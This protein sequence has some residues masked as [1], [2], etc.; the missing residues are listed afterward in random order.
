MTA[1]GKPIPAA[2]M[3]KPTTSRTGT[4][5]GGKPGGVEGGVAGGKDGGV[6]GSKGMTLGGA[7]SSKASGLPDYYART[8]LAHIGRHFKVPDEQKLDATTTVVFTIR[9]DGTIT[10]ARVRS[11]SGSSSLDALAIKALNDSKKVMALPDSYVGNSV[12][13]EVGFSFNE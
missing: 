13:V 2:G 1:S 3:G 7:G 9:R 8:V 6:V 4:T 10:G 11:S 12:E 5:A